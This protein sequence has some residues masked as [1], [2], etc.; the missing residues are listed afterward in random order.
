MVNYW[1]VGNIGWFCNVLRN[2]IDTSSL[3]TRFVRDLYPLQ[4]IP[5]CFL[6]YKKNDISFC[7][8]IF[9]F[10]ISK[11][12]WVVDNRFAQMWRH[13]RNALW[14][15]KYS[16]TWS[17]AAYDARHLI[18]ALYLSFMSIFSKHFCHSLC[19]VSHKY[20]YK[21]VKTAVRSR[22]TLFV[23]PVPPQGRFFPD[24]VINVL[25]TC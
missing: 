19:S 2:I 4:W 22:M 14:R 24:D 16:R 12:S 11:Q 9:S 7:W 5:H 17:D 6:R 8:W 25:F 18:R 3:D 20:Y 10:F 1:C 13:L 23:P 21:L 15:D